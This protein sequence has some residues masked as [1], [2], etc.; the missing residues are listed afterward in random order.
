MSITLSIVYLELCWRTGV[1]AVGVG[2]PGHFL[3]LVDVGEPV[4]VDPFDRGAR[5]DLAGCIERFHRV[6]GQLATFHPSML[7]PVTRRQ[8]LFRVL[9][10]LKNI[11]LK[12]LDYGRALAAIDRMLL[13]DPNAIG[14]YR[15]RAG[16][17]QEIGF[18]G[19]T[20]ADYEKYLRAAPRAP[21]RRLVE[22]GLATA[23][24]NRAW[25]N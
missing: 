8:I 4:Y 14:E 5:L 12:Q 1:S 7:A 11:Y 25:S 21:D 16:I 22:Q 19:Q 10:N 9:A 23:V 2:L 20:C 17:C 18:F 15:D 13:L 6:H 24:S 3:V